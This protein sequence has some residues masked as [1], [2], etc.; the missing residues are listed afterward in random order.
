MHLTV[1][2]GVVIDAEMYHRKE[3][4]GIKRGIQYNLFG[5]SNGFLPDA[6]MS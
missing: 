3:C 2:T 4:C 6:L 5:G 1:Q